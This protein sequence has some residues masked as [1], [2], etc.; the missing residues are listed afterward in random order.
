MKVLFI[1]SG[2]SPQGISPIIENQGESLK[3][4]GINVEFYTIKGKGL[5]GY[6]KSIIPLKKYIKFNNFDIFHAHY[7]MSAFIASL[8]GAK[9]LVVSLMGSDV[10]SEKYFKYII[11]LFNWFS[12]TQ[13]IVKSEDMKQSLGIEQ[14]AIIP[15]GVDLDKFKSLDQEMCK[16]KINWDLEKKQILFAANPSRYEKNFSLAVDA[17]NLL[18]STIELKV[19]KDVPNEQ[20]PIYHNAADVVLLTSLWEGS[21]NVIKEAMACNRPIVATDVGDINWLI[22][23]AIGGYL[24]DFNKK[25]IANKINEALEVNKVD[26]RERIIELRLDSVNVAGSLIDV[27]NSI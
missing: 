8:A 27:Y 17:F 22:G 9:P 2:N 14:V 23:E 5:I 15:N 26:L 3:E 16:K 11:K 12:W 18:N 4:Q 7:S 25:V 24:V 1:S 19:L 20:M 10:K 6:L 13:I 21:P